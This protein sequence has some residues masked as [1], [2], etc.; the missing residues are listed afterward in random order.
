[1]RIAFS[2]GVLIV[3]CSGGGDQRPARSPDG[4][5]APEESDGFDQKQQRE[6]E[7]LFAGDASGQ[8][9]GSADP[10]AGTNVPP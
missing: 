5:R 8:A 2:L 4:Q 6:L 3:A 10:D 1:M 7:E 9:G